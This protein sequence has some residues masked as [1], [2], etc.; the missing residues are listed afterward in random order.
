MVLKSRF[1]SFLVIR[2]SNLTNVLILLTSLFF[3]YFFF[4]FGIANLVTP[5]VPDEFLV[6]NTIVCSV[7]CGIGVFFLL[8]AISCFRG[9]LYRNKIKKSMSNNHGSKG[10]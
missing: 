2:A 8:I 6:Q 4:L 1:M 9:I 3:S 7:L 5:D 10:N